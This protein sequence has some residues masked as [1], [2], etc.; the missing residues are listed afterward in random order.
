[1]AIRRSSRWT[2]A[3][4][5]RERIPLRWGTLGRKRTAAIAS[6][7]SLFFSWI[8]QNDTV[9][10]HPPGKAGSFQTRRTWEY[11]LVSL[12]RAK[13]MAITAIGRNRT[14]SKGTGRVRICFKNGGFVQKHS[15]Q[16]NIQYRL[17]GDSVQH[18]SSAVIRVHA[19]CTR[20][21]DADI[22]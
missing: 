3:S 17:R 13:T 18:G 22:R 21:N 12:S 7:S 15:N 10:N 4:C 8:L 1:M 11:H 9:G 6:H 16:E 5:C 14:Y 2:R 19:L 20:Y